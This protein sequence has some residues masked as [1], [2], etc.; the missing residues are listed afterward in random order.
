MGLSAPETRHGLQARP[1]WIPTS[2]GRFPRTVGQQPREVGLPEGSDQPA[3]PAA[4]RQPTLCFSASL[5]P[6][7]PL[8]QGK[9]FL[10]RARWPSYFLHPVFASLLLNVLLAPS[11]R[12]SR[13]GV[14]QSLG[15]GSALSP[16]L[17]LPAEVFR[18][19]HTQPNPCLPQGM[20]KTWRSL[21][22]RAPERRALDQGRSTFRA[23]LQG[24]ARLAHLTA[25]TPCS[26][27]SQTPTSTQES[28]GKGARE[29]EKG[30]H[31][32]FTS[33]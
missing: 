28:C 6:H 21:N 27:H 24:Q 3:R 17:L 33:W 2:K 32:S 13:S 5:S 7:R 14:R 10:C 26:S 16:R 4:R 22:S 11:Q 25:H 29:E 1:H 19:D 9:G 18:K 23:S 20:Q 31:G 15:P 8:L 30:N 12:E